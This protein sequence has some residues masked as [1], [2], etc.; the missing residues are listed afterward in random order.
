[1]SRTTSGRVRTR[2]SLHPSSAAP[3]KSAPFRFRCCSIVPIAPSSTRIRCA[4][5]SRKALADSFRLRI[6]W[7]AALLVEFSG[8]M[9]CTAERASMSQPLYFTQVP[10]WKRTPLHRTSVFFGSNGDYVTPNPLNPSAILHFLGSLYPGT[11]RP[12]YHVT[13]REQLRQRDLPLWPVFNR[14]A[15]SGYQTDF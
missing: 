14:L 2:F 5:N 10:R 7:K 13:V 11:M 12:R 9:D 8:E 6:R 4:S 3:P 15:D 1:M